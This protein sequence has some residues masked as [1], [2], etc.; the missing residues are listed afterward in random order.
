MS[1]LTPAER[2]DAWA[3]LLTVLAN[4]VREPD[5]ALFEEVE[6]GHLQAALDECA[7]TLDLRPAAGT[8][9]PAVASHGAM[10]ES[11]LGL[12]GAMQTPY[13]PLA[14]SPYKPWYG[15]RSGL[16]GGPPATDMTRR[17]ETIEAA[18]PAAYPPD[19]LALELE[20]GA[21]LLESGESE[22]FAAFVEDHLDWIPALRTATDAATTEAS[23]HRW[24]VS[25]VDEVT[26]EL[27]VRC[28]V[29]PVDQ[30]AVEAMVE[31][32]GQHIHPERSH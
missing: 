28:D 16:M 13:A 7:T 24:A 12:F 6:D 1:A 5:E 21:L 25:L 32:T 11:Y 15:S 3:D 14:E 26:V 22:A 23:F 10:T 17:Y 9:P 20:Y 30:D 29:P 18:F 31:R 8:T 2:P 4:V 27:R 19:H